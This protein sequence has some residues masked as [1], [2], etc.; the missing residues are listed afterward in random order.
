MCLLFSLKTSSVS[1]HYTKWCHRV[2]KK[3]FIK[4]TNDFLVAKT[5]DQCLIFFSL[6]L[7][8]V[9]TQ[10]AAF[11]FLK[12]FINLIFKILLT[13]SSPPQFI[14]SLLCHFF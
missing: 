9:L 10:L 2:I 14:L 5:N 6:N 1:L 4:V 8:V 12:H 13:I 3:V 7:L 11:S